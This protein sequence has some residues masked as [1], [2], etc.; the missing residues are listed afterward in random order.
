MKTNVQGLLDIASKLGPEGEVV[1]AVTLGAMAISESWGGVADAIKGGAV[2]MEKGAAIAGAVASSI[3]AVG[4]IMAAQSAAKVAGI[5]KEIKAEQKRDGKSQASLAKIA[6]L[7][8]KKEA[9]K[10]KAFNQNKKMMMAQTIATTAASIMQSFVN[11]GGYPLGMPAAIAMGVIGAANLAIIAGSSYE[12]G[13][14][15]TPQASGPSSVSL[16]KRRN[17]VDMAKTQGGAGELSY[18]RGSQ[19]T[20]GPENFRGAFY[21]K[22]HRAAGGDTGY[23]VGEQGPELFMPDR[24]G[25]IVAADDTAA[26]GGGSA[27]TFNINAVDATGVEDLLVEQQGNIIGMLRQAANS[28]GEDFMEDIDTT[29]IA[30]SGARR[31]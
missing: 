11:A 9:A 13:G 1:S 29:A 18:M 3:A 27:V 22:K 24:P 25:T 30:G 15:G 5:D 21:G 23:I 26:M 12:G 20:G 16:G 4:N 28:Y 31:A 19:G 6:S 7:E 8:K 14:G 10:K 17:T 2:G